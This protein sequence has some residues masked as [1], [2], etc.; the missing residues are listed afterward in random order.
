LA[1]G[2][3]DTTNSDVV[4]VYGIGNVDT[5]L[6]V[7]IH[8]DTLPKDMIRVLDVAFVRSV[9]HGSA[10]ECGVLVVWV[11]GTCLEY[12]QHVYTTIAAC[13]KSLTR[14]DSSNI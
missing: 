11:E 9:R 7:I 5:G 14:N 1:G 6:G 12:N 10:N 3:A 2:C 4:I 8:A 13:S